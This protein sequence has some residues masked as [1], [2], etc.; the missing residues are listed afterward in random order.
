MVT[1]ATGF[2]TP[3]SNKHQ[4]S[5]VDALIKARDALREHFYVPE[6]Y[7]EPFVLPVALYDAAEREGVDMRCFKRGY[8]LLPS[9]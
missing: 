4:T 5:I 9:A 8:D 3:A 1:K 6:T 2:Q 7:A